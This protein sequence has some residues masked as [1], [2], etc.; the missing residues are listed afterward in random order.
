MKY[1]IIALFLLLSVVMTAQEKQ[2]I[3]AYNLRYIDSSKSLAIQKKI[4]LESEKDKGEEVNFISNCF[5]SLTYLR[6]KKLLH[7]KEAI[8][9]AKKILPEIVNQN[10]LGYFHYALY[11]YKYYIDEVGFE[12]NILKSLTHFESS[13]NYSFAA[14]S[15]I[16]IANSGEF[17][18]NVFL[19]KGMRYAQLSNNNDAK[20]EAQICESTYLKEKFN[21]NPK[22]ISIQKIIDSYKKAIQLAKNE[23]TNK[24]NVAMA[25][26]NYAN[27]LVT[28]NQD[29][30][31]SL[32]NIDK[33]LFYGQKYQIVSIVRN[34]YGIK[35][36]Y[37]INKNKLE[38][39]EKSFLEG[40]E[41][42]K[43]LPFKEYETE[44]KFYNDLKE[45]SASKKDFVSYHKYDL[46]FQEATN[47]ANANDKESAI[48]NAIAKYDLKSK[49]EKIALL[50]KKNQFKDGL[51]IASLLAL[52]LGVGMFFYY[53][54][55]NKIKQI[56]FE[57]KKKKLEKEKV[58][59]QKELMNSVLHLEKK[60]EILNELKVKLL[61]QNK[62][63]H[64]SINNSILKTIDAGLVLD[65]DFEKF[66]NNFNSIY[67]EFFE[68]LQQ[69]ASNLLTQLDLKYCGFIL[70]KV[71][72]KEMALQMNVEPK[73]IRMA[74]YR[75]KQ[76]LQLSKEEDLDEFIQNNK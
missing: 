76:K 59:T 45:I 12:E 26:L 7:A 29:E 38:E 36:L 51:V 28:N 11:R 69:K 72:N 31:H 14:L 32:Y 44:K 39:A 43:K 64:S 15:A 30:S 49:E 54:K 37:F 62:E 40:I 56:Y 41:Y 50:S 21:S 3:D 68:R 5:L 74:R 25:Y 65:D 35:G 8:E 42:L 52:I 27:F 60:N 66:K 17:V 58:Q 18:N 6:Q 20:L 70:M 34:C 24:M 47:S 22:S 73:S 19:E 57:Q 23:T 61:E 53:Y 4:E 55:S 16:S 13:K 33:A 71:T 2:I 75:I 1:Q 46:L 9:K 10:A 63:Q 67:P 48:Q